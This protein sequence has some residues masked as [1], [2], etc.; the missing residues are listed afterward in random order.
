MGEARSDAAHAR[1]SAGRFDTP[2]SLARLV[3]RLGLTTAL[4]AAARAPDPAA[5]IL[6]I[7]VCDPTCGEGNLLVE[8]ARLLASSLAHAR[9]PHPSVDARRDARAAVI[10]SC[11]RGVVRD[12]AVAGRC[13]ENLARE[14]GFEGV[15]AWLDAVVVR[16]DAARIACEDRWAATF[17]DVMARGGFDAVIGNPPFLNAIERRAATTTREALRALHPEI[18]ATADVSFH[19]LAIAE[20]LRSARGRVAMVMPRTLLSAPAAAGLRAR[21]TSRL[22]AL[23]APDAARLFEGA[24][25]FVCVVATG[26]GDGCAVSVDPDP[27]R[28]SWRRV[29]LRSAA[30]WAALHGED[31]PR[32]PEGPTLSERFEL[33]ASMTASEAYELAPLLVDAEHGGGVALVTTGLIDRGACHWGAR[34]CRYLKRTFAHPRVDPARVV[35]AS[36]ARRIRRASRPKL[37]VAGLGREIECYLDARGEYLGAV[38]TWT[39]THPRDDLAALG[40]LADHLHADAV[41]ARLRAELGATALGGG[42][43][44]LTR[45]FLEAIPLPFAAD[46]A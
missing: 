44:T 2:P 12:P 18:G 20:T 23:Y 30:W 46:D 33:N 16:D 32:A 26:A 43:I 40:A 25:V 37:L 35:P 38:S 7:R 17:S 29:E 13:R 42:S 19:F 11:L 10:R 21:L 8:A 31:R 14:G 3:A 39:I 15:P 28:V 6:A 34:P 22:R 41:R 4:E 5:A 45:R 27:S 1:K 24:H 9:A 36:I